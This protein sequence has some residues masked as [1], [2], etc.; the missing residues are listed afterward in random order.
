MTIYLYIDMNACLINF[1][2]PVSQKSFKRIKVQY[3]PKKR[4]QT[5]PEQIRSER[6]CQSTRLP[7]PSET[8]GNFCHLY[9]ITFRHRKKQITGLAAGRTQAKE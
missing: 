6:P 1:F 7:L 2:P 4:I 3:D 9:K 8:A 5:K